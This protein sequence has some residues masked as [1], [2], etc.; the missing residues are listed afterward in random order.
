[1]TLGEKIKKARL[2]R[3]MTQ[4][5]VVGSYITRVRVNT[6]NGRSGGSRGGGGGGGGHRGGR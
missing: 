5:D 1:M 6:N 3:H 4:R 2:D